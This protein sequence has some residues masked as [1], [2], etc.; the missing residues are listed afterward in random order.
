M[1]D[2]VRVFISHHHSP[3]EDM[4]TERLVNELRTYGA[5]V[6][7]DR[8]GIRADD[9][10]RRISE[11]LAGRQWL[12]LI[13]TPA[14]LESRW[15]RQEVNSAL[16]EVIADRMRGVLPIQISPCRD[17][18]IPMMW[19]TLHRI[20][21]INDYARGRDELLQTLGLMPPPVF[22]PPL[23]RA[24]GRKSRLR[25]RY[26]TARSAAYGPPF[27]TAC[28][29]GVYFLTIFLYGNSLHVMPVPFAYLWSSCSLTLAS[30]IVAVVLTAF[31]N[32]VGRRILRNMTTT[33]PA[34][35]TIVSGSAFASI[36]LWLTSQSRT[37]HLTLPAVI[38]VE[39]AVVVPTLLVATLVYR[40]DW[41]LLP[42]SG[43]HGVWQVL[44]P[45]V[46]RIYSQ[47]RSA[48]QSDL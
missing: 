43:L 32:L 13:M 20:N 16:N 2:L 41:F 36:L 38:A 39:L 40:R 48:R 12:I 19:R 22:P 31:C 30:W 8:E 42:G 35:A 44:H 25:R 6:W 33:V 9:F 45:H 29:T 46:S 47:L 18:E 11:G 7:V 1:P 5:D 10:V 4:F 14:S 27:L 26:A 15:V 17:E 28:I 24:T 23:P 34:I 21:A 3:V 37:I